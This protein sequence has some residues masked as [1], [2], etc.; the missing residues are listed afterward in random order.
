MTKN[1]LLRS[2]NVLRRTDN[3]TNWLYLA[4]EYLLLGLLV[5]LMIAFYHWLHVQGLSWFYAVPITLPAVALIG[6]GQHRLTTLG[7]EAS[8]YLLFRNRILNELV[9]DW[10]C[11]FPM[12]STTH[13]YRLQHLAHH[14]FPN[15]PQRDPDVMQ[16]EGS[17]HRFHFPMTPV[18]F[19]WN[20]IIKQALWLPGLI[21]YIRMRAHYATTGGGGGPYTV[22]NPRTRFL[23]L[24]GAVYVLSLAA[25]L[26]ILTMRDEWLLSII[27]PAAMWAVAMSLYA[28]V[29][30][31]FYRS[32]RLK[33][34]VSIR[35]ISCGR[36]TYVTLL[37]TALACLCQLT[38]EPW[39][40]YYLI[41]WCLP[42]MTG[43]AFCMIARQVVQHGHAGQDRFGN[44][45]VFLVGRFIRWA[46]F[47]LGM[48]YHLP[49]HLF[50][51][52]PHY[53]LPQLHALLLE[54]DPEYR[55][56]C[57]IVEGYVFHRRPPEHVT[58]LEVMSRPQA[59]A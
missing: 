50:P 31:H 13:H 44:T 37:F 15:D 58:V 57:T 51:L 55:E 34:D 1:E 54:H 52:V 18:G 27:V 20:C 30:R 25:I 7:H 48:D 19:V 14:Q 9:S 41:L 5:G 53:R 16:M 8:H 17:G 45:R 49:H 6:A 33:P 11:M 47:P 26:T 28:L 59:T 2:V 23:I 46:V 40:L 12:W 10:L 22:H 43:F 3:T 38:D 4:R 24:F 21:R 29:P 32:P 56:H 42:M 39:G 36:L 35:W